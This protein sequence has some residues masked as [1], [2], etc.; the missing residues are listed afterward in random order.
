MVLNRPITVVWAALTQRFQEGF[1]R[2]CVCDI[3]AALILTLKHLH[4]LLALKAGGILCT[5]VLDHHFMDENKIKPTCPS[6]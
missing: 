1:R 5:G 6:D 4:V 3:P 2:V